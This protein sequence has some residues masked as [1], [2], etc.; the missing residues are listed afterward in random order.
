M[1]ETNKSVE[2]A[3]DAAQEN[4]GST[5]PETEE[6]TDIAPPE[7]TADPVTELTEALDAAKQEAK[8]NYDK[9]L[10]LSAEM[11]NY[12]KRTAKELG[13]FR[14]Y[15]NESV[16]RDLLEVVDNLERALDASESEGGAESLREGIQLIL[17][18]LLKIF[19]NFEVKPIDA[20]GEPFDPVFHQAVMQEET[21]EQ[22]DNTVLRQLQKGYTLHDRLLR[23]AMV[24]VAKAGSTPSGDSQTD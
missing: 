18:D 17:D 19:G 21:D 12:K 24:V 4:D 10:R 9:F 13:D 2:P 1:A 15:A 8:E 5:P 11:E 7:E 23:P 6:H 3:D 20:L 14:K 22:P 16:M